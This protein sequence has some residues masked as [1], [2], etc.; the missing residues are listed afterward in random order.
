MNEFIQKGG[1]IEAIPTCQENLIHSP[2]IFFDIDPLGEVKGKFYF[3]KMKF[4]LN[5]KQK[6]V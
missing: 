6:Y 4:G 5:T 3:K 2:S 1:N